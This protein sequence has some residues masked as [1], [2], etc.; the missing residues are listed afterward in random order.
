[1]PR[2]Q[3]DSTTTPNRRYTY[4]DRADPYDLWQ[5]HSE[6]ATSSFDPSVDL[7][8]CDRSLRS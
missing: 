2:L 1:M 3:L 8:Y 7:R 6:M 4:N 5:V